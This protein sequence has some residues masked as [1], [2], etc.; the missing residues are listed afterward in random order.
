MDPKP[1][2]MPSLPFETTAKPIAVPYIVKQSDITAEL[3][4]TILSEARLVLSIDSAL[5]ASNKNNQSVGCTDSYQNIPGGAVANA[6]SNNELTPRMP[7]INPYQPIDCQADTPKI[8]NE[9]KRI[10]VGT[11]KT[12]LVKDN[13]SSIVSANNE[14]KFKQPTHRGDGTQA[15]TPTT[16]CS[17]EMESKSFDT[18]DPLP[19]TGDVSF[20]EFVES[21]GLEGHVL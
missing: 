1:S 17:D 15:A 3:C 11:S 14:L 16:S 18:I 2:S 21:I 19:L 4:N 6:S 20:D 13:E 7:S 12:L 8:S 10:L 9:T 5:S